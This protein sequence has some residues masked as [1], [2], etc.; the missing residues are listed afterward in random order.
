MSKNKKKKKKNPIPPVSNHSKNEPVSEAVSAENEVSA[1]DAAFEQ[2]LSSL[3][4][5]QMTDAVPLPEKDTAVPEEKNPPEG[6]ITGAA[7]SET[8]PGKEDDSVLAELDALFSEETEHPLADTALASADLGQSA[9]SAPALNEKK[10]YKKK[11]RKE[12]NKTSETSVPETPEE[13]GKPEKPQKQRQKKGAPENPA[14]KKERKPVDEGSPMYLL[15]LVL[16]LTVISAVIAGMLAAVNYFTE[17]IIAEN[18]VR[19]KEEAVLSV[20]PEGDSCREYQT[21]EGN[22]VYFA[23]SGDYAIGYCVNV[24]PSGYGGNID[25]MIG[26]DSDGSVA[27]IKI[28]SLSETPGVG[29]KVNSS[30]FLSQFLGRTN[31]EALAVGENVDGI[32]GATFSSKAVTAGVSEALS[33]SFDLREAAASVGLK[34]SDSVNV[35]NN[36]ADANED[37]GDD[38]LM[39]DEAGEVEEHETTPAETAETILPEETEPTETQP[40]E[41][42][43]EE[44]QPPETLPPETQPVQGEIEA[45]AVSEVEPETEETEETT[46]ATETLPPETT[47][48]ETL[49]PETMPPETLPPE[50]MPPETLPPETMPPETMPPETMPPEITEPEEPE[51]AEPDNIIVDVEIIDDEPEEPEEPADTEEKTEETEEETKKNSSSNKGSIIIR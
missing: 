33:V 41:V 22:T 43:P 4:E 42:Q 27:G 5:E 44:T 32:G 12:I 39:P 14:P 45:P 19:E 28:V 18:A 49:P 34:I 6:E 38:I 11:N 17:D 21:P 20:F 2:E 8:E 25:M 51:P 9:E 46:P 16:V 7:D 47:P 30:T 13:K 37:N 23:V 1:G 48:P 24:S 50:T 26:I 35:P 40:A 36:V 15:K 10:P 31:S 29:T 3:F